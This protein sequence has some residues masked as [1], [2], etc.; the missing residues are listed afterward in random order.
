MKIY[1]YSDENLYSIE[2]RGDGLCITPHPKGKWWYAMPYKTNTHAPIVEIG[3]DLNL[4][5]FELAFEI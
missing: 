3:L 5:G 2:Q 1:R 4:D